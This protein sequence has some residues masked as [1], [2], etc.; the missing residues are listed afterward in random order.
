MKKKA[1]PLSLL[2]Q[3]LNSEPGTVIKLKHNTVQEAKDFFKEC[4]NE[5]DNLPDYL[6]PKK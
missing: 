5:F 6:K 4:V 2:L 1:I 3:I